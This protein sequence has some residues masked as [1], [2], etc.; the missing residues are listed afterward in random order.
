MNEFLIKNVRIVNPDSVIDGD[1]LIKNGLI[2]D[3]GSN[4][5]SPTAKVIEGN[6]KFAFPG[7]IDFHV[8]LQDKI[9]DYKIADSF[10]VGTQVALQWGITT[11][12]SFVTQTSTET[13]SEAVAKANAKVKGQL[14]TD[15]Q[16]RL[17][18][19]TFDNSSMNDIFKLIESGYSVFKFFT[20]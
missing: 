16:W 17:T 8:H 3:S 13:L 15:L 7:F 11:I 14:Y 6:G 18:P 12:G 19:I 2:E 5:S 4:L 20:T 9:G 1:I 10:A